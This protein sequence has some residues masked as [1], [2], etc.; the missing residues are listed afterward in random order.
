MSHLTSTALYK[1]ENLSP[2]TYTFQFSFV[3]Y[4]T[5]EK[6]VEVIAGQD[7]KLDVIMFASAAALDE[8]VIKTTAKRETE[9]A[10][11]LNQKKATTIKQSIGAQELSRK[12]IS[13]A[14]GAVAKISGVSKQEGSEVM[15]TF[16]VL[17]DRYLNTTYKRPYIT[18]KR[19]RKQK[20]YGP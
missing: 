20:E 6:Q 17:G 10:L 7:T 15:Y 1:I 4:E 13:D 9:T 18:V 19:H 16:E 8:V 14:A 12:G 3:G 11:L 2:G 5:I